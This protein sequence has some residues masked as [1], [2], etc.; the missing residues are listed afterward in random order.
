MLNLH[1][2]LR[3]TVTSIWFKLAVAATIIGLLVYFN[4]IDV[5]VLASL[6]KTWPWLLAAFL[7]TLPPFWIVSYRFKVILASQGFFVPFWQALRWTM[8]GSFFDLAMPSSNGGDFIKAGYVVEH[9]GAGLRTRAVMAVAIDRVIGLLGLFLLANVVSIIGWDMLKDLPARNLVVGMSFAAG[10]GPLIAF[11]IAGSRCLYNN[12][13]IRSWLGK[14]TWG[15]RLTQMIASFNAL[16]EN[17]RVLL[18]ALGLS[19]LNHIFWCTSLLFI[20]FAV[21]DA[22]SPMKGFI[23]FP[24]AIFGGVF[25]VAGGFGFGTAAFD[26]LLSHLLLIQNG[27]IIGLLFQIFG[28]LSRLLGLPYYLSAHK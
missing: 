25:G 21:G 5:A 12:S 6:S 7:L 24:L 2:W 28:A 23:V 9:V 26:F 16:R 17:P 11:R 27:A 4:R 13:Y 8:I 3:R 10:I 20:A 1:Y 18:V 19:L 14:Y 15:Q 22:V